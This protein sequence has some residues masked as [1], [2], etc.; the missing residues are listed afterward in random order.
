MNNE[1]MLVLDFDCNATYSVLN[2]LCGKVLC[3]ISNL[4]FDDNLNALDCFKRIALIIDGLKP[5]LL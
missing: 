5:I 2:G 4:I 3:A 1:K